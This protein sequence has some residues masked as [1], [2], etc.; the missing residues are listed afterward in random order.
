MRLELLA[1]THIKWREC[2]C[3]RCNRKCFIGYDWVFPVCRYPTFF[4]S[5]ASSLYRRSLLDL[6]EVTS[7]G[8]S[9]QFEI[10]ARC[11]AKGAKIGEVPITFVDRVYGKS[12][13]GLKEYIGFLKTILH[14]VLTI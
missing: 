5:I 4:S 6:P 12:K 8:F 1:K 13:L 9:F 10:I 11:Y 7:K 2:S 14:L 3:N